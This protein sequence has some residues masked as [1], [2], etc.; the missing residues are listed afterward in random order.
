MA[1]FCTKCGKELVDGKEC[2]CQKNAKVEVAGGSSIVTDLLNLVKGMFKAPVDTMKSFINESNFNNALISLGASA[3]AAAIMIC[4]LMKEMVGLFLD[5]AFGSVGLS[6]LSGYASSSI[7]IPYAKIAI[8]SIV[9]VC[10]TYAL[11]AAIA[12]LI[13]AKLFKNQTSYKT[14]L[15]WLG[16]NAGLMTVVYLVTAVCIFI[17]MKIALLVYVVGGLLNTCYM[18]K[19]LKYACDTDENKLAYVLAPSVLVAAFVVGFLASKIMM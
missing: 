11:I 7:E 6:G 15:T 19:G 1:K 17:S 14:M 4:I 5:V 3:V 16:A 8:I 18:Y 2:S 12:Y 10:A 9:V 13:V